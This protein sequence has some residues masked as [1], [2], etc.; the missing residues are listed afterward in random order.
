MSDIRRVSALLV[1]VALLAATNSLWLFPDEGELAYT[2]ERTEIEV[3]DGTLSYAEEP[4]REFDQQNDMSDVGCTPGLPHGSRAC[5]FDKHIVENGP[6]TVSGGYGGH[7]ADD[8][9]FVYLNGSYYHRVSHVNETTPGRTYDV[10]PISPEDLLSEMATNVS[11][12]DPDAV[13]V[14]STPIQIVVTGDEVTTT[15]NFADRQLGEV[16]DR[17]GSYYAVVLTDR[18]RIDRPLL[19]P[20]TRQLLFFGGLV[21]LF[22]S[23]IDVVVRGG[24]VGE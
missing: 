8:P 13:E 20:V 21:V 16:Y 3:E 5:A 19:S 18:N 4:P 1:V 22:F 9:P 12:I 17:D 2:Y 11:S 15:R 14:S 6:V 23:A 24:L 10:E 7:I